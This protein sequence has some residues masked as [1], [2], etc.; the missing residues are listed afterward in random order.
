V[1]LFALSL[2][3]DAEVFRNL[4]LHACIHEWLILDFFSILL[5][6]SL[7]LH[8]QNVLI[9]HVRELVSGL[10]WKQ[11]KHLRRIIIS[12]AVVDCDIDIVVLLQELV[13]KCTTECLKVNYGR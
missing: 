2:N 13:P 1:S 7:C 10:L 4:F 9:I 11:E 8:L 3:L 6:I 12:E 5:L